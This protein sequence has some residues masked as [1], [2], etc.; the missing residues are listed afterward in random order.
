MDVP[1]TVDMP[2]DMAAPSAPA[3]ATYVHAGS[4]SACGA[5]AK[6]DPCG[7]WW[8]VGPSCLPPYVHNPE[9]IFVS[10]ADKPPASER[11]EADQPAQRQEKAAPA[12]REQRG[13]PRDRA[14]GN[15]GGDTGGD[16]GGGR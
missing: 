4:C 14:L 13:A 12:D 10:N 2:A 5:T 7:N 11:A 8:H 15:T 9:V 16:S 6:C 1:E 3:V